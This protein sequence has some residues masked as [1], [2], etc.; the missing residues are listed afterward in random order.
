MIV[1]MINLKMIQIEDYG[2]RNRKLKSTQILRIAVI[3]IGILR[4]G[5]YLF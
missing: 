3:K 2:K 5:S 4:I 1:G